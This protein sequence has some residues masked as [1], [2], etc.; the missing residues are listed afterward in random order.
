MIERA[1]GTLEYRYDDTFTDITVNGVSVIALRPI[2]AV[3]HPDGTGHV[4][5]ELETAGT[6]PH[7]WIDGQYQNFT[8]QGLVEVIT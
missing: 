3:V 6:T 5:T 1:D 8:H 2:E 4:L 7:M